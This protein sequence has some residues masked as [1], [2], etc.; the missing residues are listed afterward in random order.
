MISAQEAL[1]IILDSVQPLETITVSLQRSLRLTLGETIV[2]GENVPPF[3]NAAMDGY[4]VRSSDTTSAPATLQVV[5]EI[6]AGS[7]PTRKLLPGEAMSI[8]TGAKIPE[9]CDAVVQFEGTQQ[10]NGTHVKI[11]QAYPAGHNIRRSGGDIQKGAVVLEKGQVLRPQEIGV[12]ASLGKLFVEVYRPAEVAILTSGNEVVDIDKPATEGS[13]R[14]SNLYSLIALLQDMH[15]EARNLGIARDDRK[16][17]EDKI[18]EGLKADAVIASG[19]VSVGKYDLVIDTLKRLGSEI[20]FWK[21]NIKPGMPLM[22]G[23]CRGKPVFGL[24]GNPVSTVVTF[25]QFVKPALTKMMGQIN[26]DSTFRIRAR[27]EHEIEKADGK[28]HYVRGI[29][30]NR[31]GLLYV[32]SSGSQVSNVLSSL[33]KANCFIIIPEE[34]TMIGQGEDA[35]VELL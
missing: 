7:V 1:R 27:L 25:L 32:R 3:D 22:F 15:A 12:L 23:I 21:V 35:E 6:S 14:N 17:L 9:G 2:A 8:M 13:V 11:L 28:R 19:G 30:E 5:G 26:Y 29:L 16:E 20:K 33:T 18:V 34:K 31:N 10:T 24:P 4:A